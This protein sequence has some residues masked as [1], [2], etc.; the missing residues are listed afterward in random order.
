MHKYGIFGL[1]ASWSPQADSM[2]FFFA[3]SS[4]LTTMKISLVE[5]NKA[6]LFR[7]GSHNVAPKAFQGGTE[8]CSFFAPSQRFF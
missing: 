4:L 2:K 7:I 5:I 6:A 1:S 3:L 8:P